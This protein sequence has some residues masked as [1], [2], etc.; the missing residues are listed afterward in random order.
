MSLSGLRVSLESL[1]AWRLHGSMICVCYVLE[2]RRL[3][4]ILL[5][6]MLGEVTRS[7]L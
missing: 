2:D 4:E 1:Q 3:T 6:K 7:S 5:Q